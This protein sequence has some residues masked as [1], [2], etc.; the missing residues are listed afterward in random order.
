MLKSR[1]FLREKS[2]GRVGGV[3]RLSPPAPVI[4]GLVPGI[5]SQQGTNLVNKLALLLHKCWL[6][7]DSWDKPKNDGCRGRGFSAYSQSG[8]SM[9]E[10]LGVLAIIGVLSVG[11][12]A[13]YSKAMEMWNINKAVEQYSYIINGLIKPADELKTSGDKNGVMFYEYLTV[14]EALGLL[15]PSWSNKHD[16]IGIHDDLGN[17]LQ[18]FVRNKNVVIDFYLGGI[19]F[20]T[21]SWY[22][23]NSFSPK[24]CQEIVQNVFYPLHSVVNNVY[25]VKESYYGDA[26]CA[27]KKCLS[28]IKISEINSLC[29]ACENNGKSSCVLVFEM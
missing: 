19:G 18:F 3:N 4:L 5:L 14:V 22:K 2:R 13:G 8:R 28:G 25:L 24:L 11:G 27:S 23:S 29:H 7:E 15:P 20:E 6:R 17:Y 12:I 26:F 16:N 9:I 10:M 1:E 21:D